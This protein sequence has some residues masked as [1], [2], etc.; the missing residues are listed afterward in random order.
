MPHAE[1][2]EAIAAAIEAVT[3]GLELS[4]VLQHVVDASRRLVHAR[5]AA[6]GVLNEAGDA[7]E[8]FITSGLDEATRRKI[9]P[10]PEGRGLLG[11]II[12][13]GR[14]LRVADMAQDPRAVGF[15]PHHP[16]MTSLLGVPIISKG[17]VFGNLYLSDKEDPPGV[18]MDATVAGP[19][20]FN[21][22]DQAL[23]TLFARQAAIA[24]E[25]ALLHR[26]SQQLAVAHERE[27][28]AMDLHDGIIQAIYGIGLG[29]DESRY[30]LDHDGAAARRGLDEA[31][32]GLNSVISDI[33]SYI[34]NLRTQRLADQNIMAG[35]E[36]LVQELRAHSFLAVRLTVEPEAANCVTAHQSVQLLHIVQE[37]LTNA[38]KHARATGVTV[39]LS[40][41]DDRVAD[42]SGH[43]G[44]QPR[45]MLKIE[46]NGRGINFDALATASGDGLQ[47]MRTRAAA[48]QGRLD[49]ESDAASG[50]SVT[51]ILPILDVSAQ[52]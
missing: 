36:S 4:E 27:R 46:D 26:Q 12:E 31:I 52:N 28:F 45:I 18:E 33:R 44:Q 40:L 5:Y 23:V 8:Q 30:Q 35:L 6:L 19:V 13:T 22:D 15:P 43:D 41:S 9:G 32:H 39:R 38:R 37:A 29:L 47:N 51:V 2:L 7:I 34:L 14:P 11:H 21:A 3:T 20:M 25:N 50:T 48:L 10:Y 16:P 17:R 24:I 42:D 49:L 1:R